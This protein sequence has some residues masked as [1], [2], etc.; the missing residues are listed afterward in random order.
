MQLENLNA[1][2]EQL[3]QQCHENMPGF[4]V[5]VYPS[6]NSTNTT[7]FQRARAGDTAPSLLIAM[8]Q[9]AGRGR[10]GKTWVNAPGDCLMFSLGLT[11][12]TAH[13]G[14]VSLVAGIAAAQALQSFDFQENLAHPPIGIKW[15][16][17]LWLRSHEHKLGG[18]LIETVPIFNHPSARYV[19]IGMGINIRTPH[20]P[21]ENRAISPIPPAALQQLDARWTSSQ[22]LSRIIPRL[23]VYLETLNREGPAALMPHFDKLDLLRGRT[24]QVHGPNA[25]AEPLLAQGVNMQGQLQLIHPKTR[26]KIT[27]HSTDFSLRPLSE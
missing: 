3:W 14:W 10:Q 6:I 9:T 1:T 5:E 21:A 22:A 18:I 2:A 4:T 16:N 25:P 15:P 8:E 13:W 7:L 23:F 11:M 26:E 19:I 27:L 17:D 20:I 24:L 12:D